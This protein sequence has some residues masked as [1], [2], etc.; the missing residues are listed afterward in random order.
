MRYACVRAHRGEYPVRMMCR[1]LEVSRSGFYAWLVRS[2]SLRVR[3][4]VRLVVEIREIHLVTRG[5]YGSP[6]I[7]EELRGRGYGCGRNRVAR[8][9]RVHGIAAK[10]G[11]RFRRTTDSDHGYRVVPNLLRERPAASC[12]DKVWVAD[13]TYLWTREGWLYL[14]TVMDLYSRLIVGWA[15]GVRIERWLVLEAFQQAFS[16]RRPGPELIHHSDRGSQY[17]SREFQELLVRYGVRGSMSGRGK[18]YDNAAMESFFGSL[19]VEWTEGRSYATREEAQQDLFKY[20]EL[21][22]N[23]RRRHSSLGYV[24]PAEFERNQA[25]A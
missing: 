11:R 13:I 15:T 18:C 19:K 16:M 17:A 23:R 24:S 8:L 4:D 9:M 1:L 25:V 7:H 5:S 12:P 2:E 3:Q 10:R 22:Y 21:F 14:A 6:R 20:I